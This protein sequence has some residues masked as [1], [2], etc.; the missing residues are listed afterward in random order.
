MC[1]YHS[2]YHSKVIQMGSHVSQKVIIKQAPSHIGRKGAQR[3]MVG[4]QSRLDQLH[5]PLQFDLVD[6]IC[7]VVGQKLFQF[8]LV[9]FQ[10]RMGKLELIRHATQQSL[11]VENNIAV[12]ARKKTN[13]WNF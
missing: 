10:R 9:M 13:D 5:Q 8:A 1:L 6:L 7:W 4:Y 12:V 3:Y 11:V 2:V